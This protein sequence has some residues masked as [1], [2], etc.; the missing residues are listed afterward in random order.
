MF[1]PK[2]KRKDKLKDTRSNVPP[3]LRISKHQGE[4]CWGAPSFGELG[5]TSELL[6]QSY[7]VS[8]TSVESSVAGKLC[9]IE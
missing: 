8:K 1:F 4:N 3:L 2:M 7:T 5:L 6:K 9:I